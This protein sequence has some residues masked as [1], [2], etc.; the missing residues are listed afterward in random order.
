MDPL[1]AHAEAVVVEGGGVLSYREF[2]ALHV[3]VGDVVLQVE[4]VVDEGAALNP[5]ELGDLVQGGHLHLQGVGLGPRVVGEQAVRHVV[6]AGG[7]QV[8]P[9]AVPREAVVV[10]HVVVGPVGADALH[11]P[12]EGVVGYPAVLG[13]PVDVDAVVAA[14]DMVVPYGCVPAVGVDDDPVAH[15][16]P[17][18]L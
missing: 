10:Y 13:V 16:D 4:L 8:Y 5:V 1:A 17:H 7:D 15:P 9:L 14:A 11:V 18:V 6:V 12:L 3:A 2:V